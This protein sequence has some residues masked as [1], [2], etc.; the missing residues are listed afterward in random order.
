VYAERS[1]ACHC[2]SLTRVTFERENGR[3]DYA[4]NI[5]TYC[6]NLASVTLPS[7]MREIPDY[8]F[9]NCA[10][11]TSIKLPRVEKI[12]RF[13]FTR[14]G[15]TSIDL[16]SSVQELGPGAFAHCKKLRDVK[17]SYSALRLDNRGTYVFEDCDLSRE[18]EAALR[19]VRK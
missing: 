15:F 8:M 3:R 18:T 4:D 6:S 13:A 9:S 1:A 7:N 19:K 16:P 12:G 17:L 5:F 10:K 11:L 2:S 14:C